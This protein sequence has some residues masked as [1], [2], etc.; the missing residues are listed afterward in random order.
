[1]RDEDIKKYIETLQNFEK[2][3]LGDEDNANDDEFIHGLNTLL[4]NLSNDLQTTYEKPNKLQVKIKKLNPDAVIPKYSKDGDAGLDLTAIS[5]NFTDDYISY[6]TGLAF[7]IPKGYVGL[8][9]PRSSNSKKDLLLTNSVGVID[10]GYRGEI[11]LRF[12]PI[13]NNKLEKISLYDVG[14][15]IGQI[16]IIPYPQI[17]FSESHELSNTERGDGGFG[18]TN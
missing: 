4:N 17:A 1:M 11:E 10:S 9:F 16:I 13:I 18:T 5:V 12:K 7:E 6:K 15:R 3:L 2:N 14:D 8:L